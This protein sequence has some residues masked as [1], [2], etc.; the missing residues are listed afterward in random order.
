MGK[1]QSLIH[2]NKRLCLSNFNWRLKGIFLPARV[3]GHSFVLDYYILGDLNELV[4]KKTREKWLSICNIARAI[5]KVK[6]ESSRLKLETG[7]LQCG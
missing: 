3:R 2:C 1:N 7:D 6:T 5:L 4:A